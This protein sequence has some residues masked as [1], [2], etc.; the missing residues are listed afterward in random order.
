MNKDLILKN[1]I[2]YL[3]RK[4]ELTYDDFELLFNFLEK[5]EQ[6]Q[7]SN[8]IESLHIHLVDK[9]SE[10]TCFDK[11]IEDLLGHK[12]TIIVKKRKKITNTPKKTTIL[13]ENHKNENI[14]NKNFIIGKHSKTKRQLISTESNES[15][16]SKFKNTGKEIYFNALLKKNERFIYKLIHKY[17][18]KYNHDLDEDDLLQIG[19]LGFY[20]GCIRYDLNKENKLI[21][22]ISWYIRS[23]LEREIQ[24]YGTTIRI[25]TH[26][27]GSIFKLIRLME[28]KDFNIDDFI[29]NNNL[30]KEKI[31][32]LLEI[33]HNYIDIDYLDRKINDNESSTN[34]IEFISYNKNLTLESESEH[35]IEEKEKIE[36]ISYLLCFL[37]HKEREVIILRYDLNYEKGFKQTLEEIGIKFG[38]SRER[39]RQIE[40]R[41]LGKLKKL[42]YNHKL[43]ENLKQYI[44]YTIKEN[45]KPNFDEAYFFK[46]NN[47][48]Y[49]PTTQEIINRVLQINMNNS[50]IIDLYNKAVECAKQNGYYNFISINEFKEKIEIRQNINL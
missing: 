4:K 21:T 18:N 50:N 8:F 13:K 40:K 31:N 26:I 7:V 27:W 20:K 6:Y 41:A 19:K 22:Y 45:L 47:V 28:S 23:Y 25:P 44:S 46:K 14:T 36:D 11:N 42:C 43:L 1:I 29:Q 34:L 15:L 2:P 39:I 30:T 5:T 24:Q 33:K 17:A 9:K 49:I 3:N 38:V 37:T 16:I 10:N 12:K 48:S 32:K 35:V